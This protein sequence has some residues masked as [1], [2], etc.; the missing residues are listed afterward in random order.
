VLVTNHTVTIAA[1]TEN[2][3]T[4]VGQCNIS[5]PVRPDV[6][7]EPAFD[8][9]SPEDGLGPTI[10]H[11]S[12]V[13]F[14]KADEDAM[15]EP[16]ESKIGRLYYINAYG[17][18]IQPNPNPD[19]ISNLQHRDML[20]YSCGSLWT[21]LMPCLSLRGVASAI[22]RSST[23]KAKILF[24]NSENDRE[25]HNYSAVDYVQAITSTLNTQGDTRRGVHS[26]YPISAYITHLIYLQNGKVSVDV[27]E[28]TNMGIKCLEV[29]ASS[30]K[31]TGRSDVPL[32][33]ASTVQ[34]TLS[35]VQED[36]HDV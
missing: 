20:I 29:Q 19:F 30:Y 25:T 21:S 2:G 12:N 32:F 17:H 10:F 7:I 11:R 16:L 27:D 33:D 18:E 13:D 15:A 14:A 3:R 4:I 31:K 36:V 1:E 26:T 8:P 35:I 6:G 9:A 28:L 5:H 24:L 23:L 34:K 22:A